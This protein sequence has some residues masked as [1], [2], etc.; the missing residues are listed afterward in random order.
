[1]ITKQTLPVDKDNVAMK[2]KPACRKN[3]FEFFLPRSLEPLLPTCFAR[4][5]CA[6]PASLKFY[7]GILTLQSSTATTTLTLPCTRVLRKRLALNILA[8]QA[9]E[10]RRYSLFI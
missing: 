8:A 2:S 4:I 3:D 1:M 10:H 7:V 6:S 5:S 9:E